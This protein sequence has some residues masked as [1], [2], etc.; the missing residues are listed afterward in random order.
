MSRVYFCLEGK[1]WVTKKELRSHLATA[2]FE[3]HILEG[4]VAKLKKQVKKQNAEY[5][6][7]LGKK[8]KKKA[9]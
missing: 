5:N 3:I 2:H 1:M 9:K 6:E 7:L 4:Q 8:A